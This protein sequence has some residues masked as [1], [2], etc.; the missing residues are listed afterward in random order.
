MSSRR[1]RS[2]P[3]D[4]RYIQVS[5][6]SISVVEVCLEIRVPN[7]AGALELGAHQG[8]KGE[9]LAFL[10][11]SS[12]AMANESRFLMSPGDDLVDVDRPWH[13]MEQKDI[14]VLTLEGSVQYFSTQL[15]EERLMAGSHRYQHGVTFRCVEFHAPVE[16]PL[17]KSLILLEDKIRYSVNVGDTMKRIMLARWTIFRF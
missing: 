16:W 11:A 13:V 1:Q 2:I 12:E 6:Y 10:G 9:F 3:L 17:L 15:T 7:H 14:D 4:G 8:E 5:L